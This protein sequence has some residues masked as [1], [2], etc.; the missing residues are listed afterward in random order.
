MLKSHIYSPLRNSPCRRVDM[1]LRKS[2][3]GVSI[4]YFE[5]IPSLATGWANPTRCNS[6][7]H[8]WDPQPLAK[9]LLADKSRLGDE[10]LRLAVWG[11]ILHHQTWFWK[12]HHTRLE[13]VGSMLT[14]AYIAASC[15]SPL[16][17]KLSFLMLGLIIQILMEQD[18]CVRPQTLLKSWRNTVFGP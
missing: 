9:A 16:C 18:H 14:Y 12:L 11:V 2:I 7:L 6:I 1:L 5:W 13:D 17:Q 3:E 10:L 15:G 4:R 8:G